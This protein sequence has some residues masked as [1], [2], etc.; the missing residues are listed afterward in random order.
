MSASNKIFIVL[1]NFGIS[2][3]VLQK[4]KVFLDCIHCWKADIN[5]NFE[6]LSLYLY[7][8]TLVNI[9]AKLV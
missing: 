8:F 4:K 5:Y 6:I 1:H 2:Q 3:K 7:F 9:K